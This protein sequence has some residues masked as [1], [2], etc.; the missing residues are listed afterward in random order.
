[1]VAGRVGSSRLSSCS[2]YLGTCCHYLVYALGLL[3]ERKSLLAL[4]R[5]R[6]AG[7]QCYEHRDRLVFLLGGNSPAVVPHFQKYL[8]FLVEN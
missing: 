4:E 2:R 3:P 6:I 8:C 5:I 7:R 1:M